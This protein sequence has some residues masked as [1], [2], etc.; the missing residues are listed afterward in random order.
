MRLDIHVH[1]CFSDGV[2]TPREIVERCKKI[3]LSG[4]AITDH[5]VIEGSLEAL[6]YASRD[7]TVIPGLEVSSTEGHILALGVKEKIDA[8]LS[9]YDTIR[10]I[11]K[12]GGIAVAAHPYDSWRKGVGD[13]ILSLPFDAVEV[14]NGHTFGNTKNPVEMAGKAKLPTVG[15]TDAH[16]LHEIGNVSIN[17]DGEPLECIKKGKVEIKSISQLKFPLAHARTLADRVMAGVKK[18]IR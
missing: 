18:K 15:G 9:A 3:G 5:D 17:V 4:V 1:S 16:S 2:P 11:H 12:M 10:I 14:I 7:F 8:G 13:L 6:K